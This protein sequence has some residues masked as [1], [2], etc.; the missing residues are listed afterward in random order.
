MLGG[1]P[2]GGTRNFLDK[3]DTIYTLCNIIEDAN[4]RLRL[5]TLRLMTKESAPV[6]SG[7]APT[8]KV[9]V[10]LVIDDDVTLSKAVKRILKNRGW[11]VHTAHTERD[12]KIKFLENAIDVVLL[13]WQ[14]LGPP[15]LSHF[16]SVG[17]PV[18]VFTAAPET[19]TRGTPVLAKP[20]NPKE[21]EESLRKVMK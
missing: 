20:S 17:L 12:A 15:L 9:G 18:L 13:D 8:P 2:F 4:E 16:N 11:T 7:D 14:P 1:L 3:V 21:L 10:V 6:D 5:M 19:V